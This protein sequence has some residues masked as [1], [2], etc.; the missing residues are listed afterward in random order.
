MRVLVMCPVH[1]PRD[2]RIA[3]REIGALLDAGHVVT[4]AGPFSAYAAEP[5]AGVR[6]IDIPRSVGRRRLGAVREARRVL[7][8]EAPHHDVVL[9]HSPDAVLAAVGIDHPAIAWDVHEDTAAALV[10]RPWL[11]LPL[12]SPMGAAVRWGEGRAEHSRRILLAERAYASRF[13]REHPVVP[14]TP[15]VPV[16]VPPSRRGRA[17]YL[18]RLTRARGAEDL[19]ALG[20]E[21][22]QHSVAMEAIGSADAEVESKLRAAQEQRWIDWRGFI[23]NARA[24]NVLE[25]ATVGLSLLHDEANYRHSMPTKLLEYL[26]R[27]VPFVSTPLPL[28]VELAESSGAGIIVPFGDVPAARDAVLAL[29][30]DDER[31]QAMA[32]A[33][34]SWVASEANWALDGP[35]FVHILEGWAQASQAL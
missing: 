34:R 6:A 29:D 24:L 16:A 17:I 11:P 35:R 21:L 31:R 9:L 27:G 30:A 1:D 32:D 2:A 4:Q 7:K 8:R 12:A 33:G 5:R 23:P 18:G 20:R 26:A 19:I 13:T 25:G 3:E 15:R 28:A 14:N 22:R 10:M